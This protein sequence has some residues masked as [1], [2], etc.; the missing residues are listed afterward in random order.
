MK[1]LHDVA[2]PVDITHVIPYMHPSAGGPPVVV[3][4]ICK[5]LGAEGW[6][7]RVV[8]TD[9]LARK[10]PRDWIAQYG[11][12]Y[13]LTVFPSRGPATYGY[14]PA[15]AANIEGIVTRSRLVHI[16]TSWSYPVWVAMRAC[17]K[18]RIP[19]V[20]MP[21]GM[22]D[23]NSLQRKWVKKRVY[24]QFV[25]WPQIRAAA[26]MVYTHAEERRLAERAVRGL[27]PGFIV[28]LGTDP[29]PAESREQLS[30]AFFQRFP[31]L[32]GR[33]IV[34]FLSRL[35]PKKGLDL[36]IPA[37]RAVS[38]RFDDAH[39]ALVGGGEADYV[40]KLRCLVDEE[41]LGKRA[42]FTGPLNGNAKWEA[43]AAATMLALPSYQE[44]FALVVAEG[45]RIGLPVVLSRRVNIWSEVVEAGAGLPCDLTVGSVAEAICCFLADPAFARCAGLQGQQLAI[46]LF[47]WERTAAAVSAMYSDVLNLANPITCTT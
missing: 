17:R 16:H 42:T 37:F 46:E 5:R 6:T 11:P 13:E 30:E 12:D 40:A 33:K 14:S 35:H 21:H 9:T 22:L 38:N 18:N 3:D 28:P 2:T 29:P 10:L 41:G 8:T 23:P 7:N 47:N 19:F 1:I 32:R 25:E 24:G 39:L 43:M 34:L 45:M 36:L 20:V 4:R 15:L 44:N 27:P 31:H 26:A